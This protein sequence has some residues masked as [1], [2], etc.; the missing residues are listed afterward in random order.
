[1][2]IIESGIS[3]RQFLGAAAA[4]AAVAGVAGATGKKVAFADEASAGTYTAGTYTATATGIGTV[5]VTVTF[6]ETSITEV[7]LDVSNETETIGQAAADE[8][9]EQVLAAQSADIEG[10]SGATLTSTA[11]ATGVADCIEQASAGAASDDSAEEATEEEA[12]EETTEEETSTARWSWE[13][14]PDP[15]SDDEIV[16]TIDVDICVVGAGFAGVCAAQSAAEEGGSVLVLEQYTQATGRGLDIGTIGNTWQEENPDISQYIDATEAE[17]IYYEFCHGNCN[18]YLF[19]FWAQNSGEAFDHLADYLKENYDIDPALSSTA[20]P[21][22][23]DAED[24]LRE[25]PTC[26]SFGEGWYDENGNWLMQGVVDKIVTWAEDLGA[27]FRYEAPAEQLVQDE[28]GRVTGVIASTADGYI[29]VNASKGVILATGDIGGNEEMLEAY[30]P[31]ALR[32]ETNVYTPAGGNNGDGIKLGMQVGAATQHGPAAMVIHPFGSS[33]PLAQTGDPYAWLD[34]NIE[35]LRYNP[36][37]DSTVGMANSMLNQPKALG[38][39]IFDSEYYD[40]VLQMCPDN[41]GVDGTALVDENTQTEIDEAVAANDGT[42][43]TSDTIEGLAEQIGADPDVLQATVDRWNEL[44]ELGEDVDMC[45]ESDMLTPLDT[46]P[47]YA[48]KIPQGILVIMYGLNCDS[49]SRVCD[50]NDD[51]IEGL[52]AIGNIQGNFFSSDYP[53]VTPGISHGRGLTFGYKL[54]KAMLNDELITLA[55]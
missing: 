53:M 3:R 1:M 2:S 24:W 6:D 35:G 51:P 36:G 50:E 11:V 7:V 20:V 39:S 28:D 19:R 48:S 30:C 52:Y 29:K 42:C 45:L 12:A 18:R 21:S 22:H 23:Y 8:L 16:E 5:T 55:V 31:L 41:V 10:V 26:Q 4:T 47:Y 40:K 34:V 43:F 17:R 44:C 27:E 33:G 14:K 32:A 54:P 13:E 15:I 46:P 49:Y 37:I 9:I 38:Y 25:M